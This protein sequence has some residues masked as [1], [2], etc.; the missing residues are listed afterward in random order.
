MSFAKFKN[1]NENK[2]LSRIKNLF[3]YDDQGVLKINEGNPVISEKFI[4]ITG[5]MTEHI[6]RNIESTSS[7]SDAL[8]MY[9]FY[10][11][12][13]G[14][15]FS[16]M[17]MDPRSG[18]K[19]DETFAFEVLDNILPDSASRLH[20]MMMMNVVDADGVSQIMDPNIFV[21]D[22]QSTAGQESK[23]FMEQFLN[24]VKKVNDKEM[25]KIVQ[26]TFGD[27]AEKNDIIMPGAKYRLNNSI[28]DRLRT[29]NTF[30]LEK[31][32]YDV[33]APFLKNDKG[34]DCFVEDYSNNYFDEILARKYID[35]VKTFKPVPDSLNRT[36][37]K[38]GKIKL[39]AGNEVNA[40]QDINV[41]HKD[42][43]DLV[44]IELRNGVGNGFKMQ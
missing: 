23:F 41:I 16:I 44:I 40:S 29:S 11:E 3:E 10:K 8:I 25:T 15:N 6:K 43:E 34:L 4:N 20:K 35:V 19:I 42:N 32:L 7:R 17:K 5:E 9:V 27:Y 38:N 18:F 14:Y 37:Y 30:S 33:T 24:A 36:V 21:L 1:N 39:E 31:D 2:T 22:K 12:Q 26:Y 28:S 13:N